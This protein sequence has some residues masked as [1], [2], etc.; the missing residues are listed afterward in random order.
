MRYI[1]P[2]VVVEDME[3]S[4]KFY[5]EV[6][7]QTIKEDYGQNVVFHGDFAIHLKDHYAGLIDHP[8][9]AGGNNFELYFE[10]DDLD[11][12]QSDLEE[13]NVDFVHGIRTQPWQ[14]RVMRFYDPDRNIIEIGESMEDV[15]RRLSRQGKSIADIVKMTSLPEEYV[16]KALKEIIL[17]EID[18]EHI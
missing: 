8:I 6:L 9:K 18:E 4:K 2:L 13:L 14:Q 3:R 17:I 16:E 7:G 5:R 1:C 15:C 12:I 10:H 11:R